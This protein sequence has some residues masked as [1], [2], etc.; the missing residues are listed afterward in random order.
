MPLAL[1]LPFVAGSGP[2]ALVKRVV[3]ALTRWELRPIVN[4]VNDLQ[5]RTDARLVLLEREI[6]DLNRALTHLSAGHPQAIGAPSDGIGA[7]F[8]SPT[9][10]ADPTRAPAN[11]PLRVSGDI[12]SPSAE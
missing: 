5:Y 6:Q 12:G 7:E 1:R 11:V 10:A 3:A 2:R 8:F 4:R 9:G